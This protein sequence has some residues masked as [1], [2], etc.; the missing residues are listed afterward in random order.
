MS[1]QA[2][3]AGISAAGNIG[4]S[5]VT[6][7][8][9]KRS[10][11]RAEEANLKFW[12]LQNEYNDPSAQM[13]RLRKAGLNPHLIYGSNASGAS[14]NA[15]AISPAKAADYEMRNPL[16]D[17]S[18]FA[19]FRQKEAITDNLR[20]QNTVLQQEALLKSA[21]TANTQL[22]TAQSKFDL[23]LSEELRSTSLQAAQANLR[24]MEANATA[25]EI[26]RDFK[27]RSL[28]D[29]LK[30]INYRVQISRE[31]LTGEN[32]KNSLLQ[33][34]KE[35]SQLGL[36][37]NDP[38]YYRILGRFKDKISQGAKKFGDDTGWQ[39]EWKK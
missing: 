7:A 13:Q 21:T 19:D 35:L 33:W 16:D 36:N 39:P 26:E 9:N 32:L 38:W 15:E 37:K 18:T 28:A 14:G 27:D 8:G 24:R 25:D 17:V 3:A 31:Q 10:Q 6:N 4:A 29:R 22:R 5:I 20:E 11:K 12:N 2:T 23:G 1:D 34:E 30:D